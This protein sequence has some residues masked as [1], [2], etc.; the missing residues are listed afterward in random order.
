L[1]DVFVADMLRR[2]HLGDAL[3]ESAGPMLAQASEKKVQ[4]PQLLRNTL[5]LNR[6]DGTYAE[7]AQFAGLAAT[8]WTWSAIFCDVDLDGYEDL[9]CATGQM[10][11]TQ[12]P[13][14]D[15]RINALGPWPREKIPQKLL[16]YP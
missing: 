5:L 4:R 16:M 13:D 14:A 11:D 15:A 3:A 2:G 8:D 9:L 6:G 1:D 7:I 10:F 12:D